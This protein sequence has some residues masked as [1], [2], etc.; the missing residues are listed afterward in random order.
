MPLIHYNYVI[1]QVTA[2]VPN[3]ALGNP[4]LPWTSEAGPLGLDAEAFHRVDHFFIEVRYPIG[5]QVI[6]DRIVWKGFTQL[7]DDPRA[8]RVLGDATGQDSA[9]VMRNYE[10]AVQDAKSQRRHSEEVHCSNGFTVIAQKC[11]PPFYRLRTPWRLPHQ[12]ETVLS[13]ISMPSILSSP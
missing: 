8:G 9:A 11:C 6:G 2:A 5:D 12:R 13:D 4:V 1:D 10:E 7:L 3:P